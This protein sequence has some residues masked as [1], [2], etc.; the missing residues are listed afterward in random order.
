MLTEIS[1]RD[2]ITEDILLSSLETYVL[3]NLTI[4]IFIVQKIMKL[5]SF[6]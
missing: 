5:L 6:L 2:E 4:F 3:K 1:L